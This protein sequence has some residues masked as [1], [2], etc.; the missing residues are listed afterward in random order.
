MKRVSIIIPMFNVEQYLEK[1]ITSVI[2]Q[3]MKEDDFEVIMVNDESPDNSFLLATALSKKHNFIKVISQKNKGLGGAR[4]TGILN[5]S[6]KYLFFLDADDWLLPNKLTELVQMADKHILDIL[7]FGANLVSTKSSVVSTVTYSSNNKI[8]NG[9]DYFNKVKYSWSACNKLYSREFLLKHNLFFLEKVYG[10]DFEFNSRVSFYVQK[11]MGIKNISVEFLQSEN[12]ITRNKSKNAKDK[13]LN[14]FY[15]ALKSIYN[16]K[17][18][19]A[20][21]KNERAFFDERMTMINIDAFFMLLKN[22]YSYSEIEAYKT[23]LQA[24]NLYYISSKVYDKKKNLFRIIFLKYFF[25]LF[26]ISKVL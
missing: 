24:N 1:C 18:L 20:K 17:Q 4:N 5:A 6:G 14:D 2:A 7:E 12:S 16:F 13:Y 15:T 3:N 11:M 25:F 10:E 9:I 26:R 19:N 8:Y 23:K 21:T 22:K